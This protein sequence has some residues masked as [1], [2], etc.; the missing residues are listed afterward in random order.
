L[1]QKACAEVIR[2]LR[3]GIPKHLVNKESLRH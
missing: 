1:R 3:G 2:V